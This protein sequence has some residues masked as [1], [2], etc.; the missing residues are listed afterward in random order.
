MVF[1]SAQEGWIGTDCRFAPVDGNTAQEFINGEAISISHTSDAGATWEGVNLPAPQVIP[2]EIT[3]AGDNGIFCG[4]TRMT[5]I[6]G[7]AFSLEASCMVGQY[8]GSEFV[9]SYLTADGGESWHSWPASGG[10]FFVNAATGWRLYTEPD[11]HLQR[12]QRTADSGRT[13]TA[14]STVTWETAQFDFAT[15]QLGWALVSGAGASAFVQTTDGGRTWD[16]I[17]P[18]MGGDSQ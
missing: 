8:N 14:V 17:R 5:P 15:E 6:S 12:V 3:D 11:T 4:I 2:P 18:V 7:R 10:E 16:E 13:W 9:L 1:G